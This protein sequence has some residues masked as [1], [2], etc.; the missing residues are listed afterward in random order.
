[1]STLERKVDKK[2]DG[3]VIRQFLKEE[4]ELS[5]RL[6]RSASIEKR[7][8]VNNIPVRMRCVLKEGDVVTIKL[9]K[10]ESQNITPEKMDLNIVYEDDDILV[11]NKLPFMVVHPT[12]S[13][14][15]GTLAN[16]VLNYFQET[17]QNCYRS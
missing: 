7:I 9:S 16:G 17:E 1:M 15:S 5:T 4:L 10:N 6:I 3:I 13:H 2:Y 14:Q 12:K 8:L 11:L